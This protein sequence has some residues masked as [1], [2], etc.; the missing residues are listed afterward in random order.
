M[1]PLR[2]I[3][4]SNFTKDW[5][6]EKKDVKHTNDQLSNHYKDF[7]EYQ[8]HNVINYTGGFSK[9]INNHLWEKHQGY[10]PGEGAN[11][12]YGEMSKQI[13]SA[14]KNYGAPKKLTVYAGIKY[15]PRTKMDSNRI[16]HHPAYLST[17]LTKNIAKG[18]GWNKS[19]SDNKQET[20]HVLKIK[21]PKG[22]PGAYVEHFT[23]NPGEHEFILPRGMKLR[24]IHTQTH[25]IPGG[26][27]NQNVH[28]HHM[29]I[30]K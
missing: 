27:Y 24:H 9:A 17:S 15:D 21:V 25:N 13:D 29:E 14:L 4:E 23:K 1:K 2:T 22:H 30:V 7:N 28:E 18:F 3:V 26:V 16:V 8:L 20:Y 5:Q 6:T 10:D 12:S 11:E 19:E